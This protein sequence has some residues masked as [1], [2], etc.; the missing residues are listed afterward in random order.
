L[1]RAAA[2]PTTPTAPRRDDPTRVAARWAPVAIWLSLPFL[3]GPAL[4]DAL[5]VR[6]RPVQVTASVGLWLLWA[7]GM[8]LVLVP[9]TVSLTG[10]RVLGPATLAACVASTMAGAD[11]GYYAVA[12]AIGVVTAVGTTNRWVAHVQVNGSSYGDE[13]RFLLRTPGALLLGPVELSWLAIVAGVVSGPMLLAAG[14]HPAGVAAVVIGFPVAFVLLRALHGLSRRWV[15]FVPVGLVVHDYASL[16]ESILVPR[17]QVSAMGEALF[18]TAARDLTFGADGTAVEVQLAEPITV[19]L[20]PPRRPG[21]GAAPVVVEA[22]SFLVAPARP[23]ELLFEASARR[24]PAAVAPS[25]L[26]QP[27]H[28][29]HDGHDGHDEHDDGPA[30]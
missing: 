26:H 1:D 9:S 4:G 20:R 19:S 14:S 28:D 10:M 8:V 27:D 11:R 25:F 3:A 29:E 5:A 7:V 16:T 18:G 23:I 22:T 2:T 17:R 15:V 12:I 21:T 24:L 30:V 6:T 13:G